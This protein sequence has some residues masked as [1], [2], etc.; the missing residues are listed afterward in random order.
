MNKSTPMLVIV[1]PLL[2]IQ[3]IQIIWNFLAKKKLPYQLEKFT[4]QKTVTLKLRY[5]MIFMRGE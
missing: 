3:M 4:D 1:I 2:R 5:H